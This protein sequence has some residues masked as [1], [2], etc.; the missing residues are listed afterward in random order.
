M[1]SIMFVCVAALIMPTSGA[2]AD[3][4]P[5]LTRDLTGNVR[6]RL[7]A[8]CLSETRGRYLIARFETIEKE[9]QTVGLRFPAHS[10][11]THEQTLRAVILACVDLRKPDQDGWSPAKPEAIFSVPADLGKQSAGGYGLLEKCFLLSLRMPTDE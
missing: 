4:K 10:F 1:R 6:V 7:V 8:A 9:P 3:D 2:L 5:V 11:S